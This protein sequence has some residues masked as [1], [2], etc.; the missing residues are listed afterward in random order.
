METNNKKTW[1]ID[2]AHSEVTFKVKHMMISTV[3]GSFEEFNGKVETTNDDFKNA[4]FSFSAEVNSVNTKSK[5]RDNHLKSDD[6]FGADNHPKLTFTSKSF[7]G[8]KIVGDLTIKGVTKQ[9]ELDAEYNGTAVD[10]Y[11]NTKAGFEFEGQISRKDFGLS[12]N[13][14]TEAGNVVVGD[15]VKLIVALQFIKQ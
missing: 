1:K 10:P 2:L 12:W 4:Q 7:D 3:S 6:F 5:D 13:S 15:K 8:E 9:I 14:V 11:G